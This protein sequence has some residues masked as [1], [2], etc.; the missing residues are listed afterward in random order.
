VRSPATLVATWGRVP[1]ALA[2]TDF[3]REWAAKRLLIVLLASA[4]T[5]RN[6]VRVGVG[7]PN[8]SLRFEALDEAATGPTP[9]NNRDEAQR[10]DARDP[11]LVDR[12]AC[13]GLIDRSSPQRAP[14]NRTVRRRSLG[15]PF[16]IGISF[17]MKPSRTARS[18]RGPDGDIPNPCA[19][20]PPKIVINDTRGEA[21]RRASVRGGAHGGSW[22]LDHEIPIRIPDKGFSCAAACAFVMSGRFY[23]RFQ[24]Q[25]GYVRRNTKKATAK[26][27]SITPG[28]IY[29]QGRDGFPAPTA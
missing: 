4:S 27:R 23:G 11:R 26:V 9:R 2:L 18:R 25:R 8:G 3:R 22:S 13:F 17:S 29:G 15:I 12:I 20:G 6:R 1:P 19:S 24:T 21:S 28:R 10:E 14:P 7:E 16:S 5:Q